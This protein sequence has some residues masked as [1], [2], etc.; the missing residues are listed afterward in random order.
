MK[1]RTINVNNFKSLVDFKLDLAKFTCLIGLNGSGKSTVLQFIDFLSQ[2]MRGDFKGWLSERHWRAN[3][4]KSQLSKKNNVEFN[5]FLTEKSGQSAEWSGSFNPHPK[6][7]HCTHERIFVGNAF[8][9]VDDRTLHYGTGIPDHISAVNGK[10]QRQQI[11]FDYQGSIL[12][13]LREST[14]PDSLI[15]LKEFFLNVKSLDLLSPE[16]LRQKTRES[17]GSIGLGGQRLASFM[18]ELEPQKRLRLQKQLT[19]VYPQLDG[20]GVKSLRSGWKQLE[21]VEKYPSQLKKG[22]FPT[23]KTEARHINDGM[24]R[25]MAI[26]AELQSKH[27]FLLFDEIENGINPELVEFVI[28]ALTST[29]KQVLVT[30][31]SPMILNY[32]SDELA[33]AGVIYLFKTSTGVTKSLPFFS[34]PSL[35]EKL[36]VMGPGEVFVDT[37]LKELS[38]EIH[39]VMEAR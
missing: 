31:H 3:E 37:N 28:E 1:L 2:L 11:A 19:S 20:L 23:M 5:V 32:L 15:E 30:T 29:D 33:R 6:Q 24:L 9:T 13:Q 36:K 21:I 25:L 22:F 10:S 38:D 34:I 35:R 4:L 27:H 7:F 18:H 39:A 8:L 26:L 14:L 12:S 17:A 16:H